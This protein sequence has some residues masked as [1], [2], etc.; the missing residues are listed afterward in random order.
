MQKKTDINKYFTYDLLIFVFLKA[1]SLGLIACMVMYVILP[2]S[3]HNTTYALVTFFSGVAV[4]GYMY[5]KLK[6]PNLLKC[7]QKQT[8]IVQHTTE[9]FLSLGYVTLVILLFKGEAQLW[10][11]GMA[12][13][14]IGVGILS[15]GYFC[16]KS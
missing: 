4:A 5:R 15:Y 1:L 14:I 7:M 13:T 8:K 3:V 10:L 12:G 16:F 6:T 9:L 2:F 11:Y